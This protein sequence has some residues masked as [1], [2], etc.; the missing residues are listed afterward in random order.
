VCNYRLRGNCNTRIVVIGN[1]AYGPITAEPCR[2]K[3]QPLRPRRSCFAP[4]S[5]SLMNTNE[6]QVEAPGTAPGSEWFIT[7]SVYHHRQPEG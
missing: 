5:T 1:Y 2:V 7:Q 3:E 4:A 6:T